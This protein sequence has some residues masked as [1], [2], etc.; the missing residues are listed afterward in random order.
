MTSNQRRIYAI[1]SGAC[2]IA[3][4][5]LATRDRLGSLHLFSLACFATSLPF[6]A[7]GGGVM[8]TDRIPKGSLLGIL[9]DQLIGNSLFVFWAGV[10]ALLISFG[11][12]IAVFFVIGSIIAFIIARVSDRWPN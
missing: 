4:T 12:W 3:I 6:M 8:E 2:F 1:V 7:L 9:L 5:Q 10:V 11:W